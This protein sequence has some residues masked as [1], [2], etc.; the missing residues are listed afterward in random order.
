MNE[1][2]KFNISH[3]DSPAN[4]TIT[5]VFLPSNNIKT[6]TY[7]LY[8]D[9][10]LVNRPVVS[11][12][13]TKIVLS[14][15]GVYNIKVKGTLNDDTQKELSSGYYIIDKQAPEITVK[16]ENLEIKNTNIEKINENVEAKDN[17]D[18]NLTNQVKTN[19]DSLN[20]KTSKNQKLV[21]TTVDRAGNTASK[22]VNLKIIG[23]ADQTFMVKGIL[24]IFILII[25]YLIVKFQN[26][27]KIE[28]RI[29]PFSLKPIKNK[30]LSLSEK[31][32]EKYKKTTKT[33]SKNFDKSVIATKYSKKLE[34][35]LPV[36]NIHI[37][38]TDIF[39]GKIIAAFV[40]VII[41]IVLQAIRLKM[42]E[43]YEIIL[44]FTIGFFALDILYFIKYKVFRWKL[45]SDFIAAITIMNNAFKSGRS[46]TQAI[47]IV[48]QEL[49]GT[50]GKE[51]NRMSLE[52]LYGLEIDV[53]F[54]RFAKRIDLEEAS[55]LTASLTILNKTGGDII[56]VFNSIERSMFDKRKLR[57]ELASLTSGSR[58][59]VSVLLGMPFFFCLVISLINPEYFVP[60]F[61]TSI[62]IILLIFMLIYYIIFVVVVRKIM[63]VVI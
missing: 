22:E 30:K 45:E 16:T 55:Y 53:V 11:T 28:K 2:G 17:Y 18:G 62:G 36:T 52:L 29:E 39:A 20:L 49:K 3:T 27:L 10:I 42:L 1:V 5:V 43:G 24:I 54:K 38:G 14:E 63:K 33:I 15:T 44:I 26:A 47:D 37:T 31:F 60:F 35:Y 9:N 48:S 25:A 12:V 56:K 34:K 61:T 6:Y 46:I 40:F 13:E 21:Y 57:L 19:I 58:I 41:A 8:K 32:I 51:F 7:E 23:S 59:V 50:M 4:K